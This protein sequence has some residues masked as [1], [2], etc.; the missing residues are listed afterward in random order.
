MPS[1]ITKN[2]FS[3]IS[4]GETVCDLLKG[5]LSMSSTLYN[6]FDWAFD[7]DGTVSDEFMADLQ[8]TPAGML[9]FYPVNRV[10][11]GWLLCNGQAVSRATYA[12]LFAAIGTIYG[13]G[14]GATTFNLPNA[15]GRVLMGATGTY[16]VGTTGG[17]ETHTLTETEMPSHTHTPSPSVLEDSGAGDIPGTTIFGGTGLTGPSGGTL[18][19]SNTG[20]GQPHNN[21]PPYLA[22]LWLIKT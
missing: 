14:D 2:H 5:L 3:V 18:T 19:N 16:G 21:L 17:E 20:G 4:F 15:Q 6:W 22:G 12:N 1:P 13:V 11:D 7:D 10:P 8:T 9:G